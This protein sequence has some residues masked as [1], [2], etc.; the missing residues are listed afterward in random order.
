MVTGWNMSLTTEA[1]RM[2]RRVL[3]ACMAALAGA[4]LLSAAVLA[5]TEDAE[6]VL[7]VLPRPAL[8]SSLPEGSGLVWWNG[9]FAA[10]A[11]RGEGTVA[12]AYR[13]GALLVLPVRAQTCLSLR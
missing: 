9:P 8:L 2:A 3:T 12:H 10:I 4:V 13:T 6:A 5:L 7:V 1:R 11:S